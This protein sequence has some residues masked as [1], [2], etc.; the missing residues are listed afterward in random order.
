MFSA[1]HSSEDVQLDMRIINQISVVLNGAEE[2]KRLMRE[3]ER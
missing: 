3:K 2:L 1:L